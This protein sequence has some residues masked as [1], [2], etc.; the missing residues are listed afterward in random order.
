VAVQTW[1]AEVWFGP[2]ADFG[3]GPL[4]D[5]TRGVW[6]WTD[7]PGSVVHRYDPALDVDTAIPVAATVGT[8]TLNA[9]GDVVAACSDG[10]GVLDSDGH[11]DLLVPIN[12]DDPTMRLNDGKCDRAGRLYVSSMAFAAT[13]GAGALLRVDPDHSV[14]TLEAGTTI[15]NGLGWS[16]DDRTFFYTDSP[17][18]RVDAYDVDPATGDLSGKRTVVT[19]PEQD[20]I[21]DG[22]CVDD[23]GALWVALWGGGQVRRY[24]PDGDLLGVVHLPVSNVTCPAFGGGGWD[25]LVI[26]TAAPRHSGSPANE[27]LG[28]AVF[29]IRPGVTGP[30]PNPYRG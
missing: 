13:E 17:T 30:P 14:H 12:A 21:P 3:E 28:G 5:D 4:W 25:Q 15:G 29:R 24:T 27:P 7:I 16:A 26:T 1:D 18:G 11:I 9:A 22:F 8:L 6:W 10:V 23:E 20:G 2:T 19:I